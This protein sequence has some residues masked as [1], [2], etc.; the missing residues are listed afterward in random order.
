MSSWIGRVQR[1][2]QILEVHATSACVAVVQDGMSP[3][4]ATKQACLCAP[5]THAGSFRC[6][7]H[8]T[9]E[10]P[11]PKPS[12]VHHKTPDAKAPNCTP[13]KNTSIGR[14]INR[15]RAPENSTKGMMPFGRTSLSYPRSRNPPKPSRLSKVIYACDVKENEDVRI[16]LSNICIGQPSFSKPLASANSA[17]SVRLLALK[18]CQNVMKEDILRMRIL[19]TGT[20]QPILSR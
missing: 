15:F 4:G 20:H 13:T 8:R 7:F 9:P 2:L 1:F 12:S 18:K 6:R 14:I 11:L 3:S 16:R 10:K 5:T 17:P 19:E